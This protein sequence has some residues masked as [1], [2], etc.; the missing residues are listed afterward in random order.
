MVNSSLTPP[1]PVC[2]IIALTA[3][4]VHSNNHIRTCQPLKHIWIAP[5]IPNKSKVVTLRTRALF[6]KTV[7]RMKIAQLSRMVQNTCNTLDHSMLQTDSFKS[8]FLY[9]GFQTAL[10]WRHIRGSKDKD[11]HLNSFCPSKLKSKLRLKICTGTHAQS[12]S[13]CL[14]NHFLKDAIKV[15]RI[16]SRMGIN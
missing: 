15:N 13:N 7:I 2:R 5:G 8:N 16:L 6:S 10:L 1:N 3:I 12:C 11:C 9:K 4:L 14:I